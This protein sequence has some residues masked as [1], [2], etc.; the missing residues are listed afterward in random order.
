MDG[1]D[2]E[3]N[4][5]EISP[6]NGRIVPV[7]TV[8]ETNPTF[9]FG[10]AYTVEIIQKCASQVTKVLDKAFPRDLNTPFTHLRRFVKREF[11]PDAIKTRI[12]NEKS[13][14]ALPVAVPEEG[15]EILEN[16]PAQ[17][18]PPVTIFV[19]IPPP[20][21]EEE[22]LRTLLAPFVPSPLPNQQTDDSEVKPSIPIHRVTIPLQPPFNT[23]QAETW[24]KTYWPT[25]FNAASPR[26]MIAPPPKILSV[27]Q[28]SIAP[29]AGYYL[30]LAGEI[31]RE[32]RRMKRGRGIG[33]VIVD[34]AIA[35]SSN[36][37]GRPH[38][39]EEGDN[40]VVA[41]AGDARYCAPGIL[42][43][44]DLE[45][46]GYDADCEGGPEFHAIM[47]AVEMV[48]TRRRDDKVAT[49][50]ESSATIRNTSLTPL[51][52]HYLCRPASS[53]QY[54]STTETDRNTNKNPGR[55]LS[56]A[57]GGYLC[58]DL[59]IYITHEPCLACSMGMLLS[60][61]RA[62]TFPR[63]GRLV[64]GGL[65]SMEVPQTSGTG[66]LETSEIANNNEN[67]DED[68][69]DRNG[70]LRKRSTYYG[71]HW[72]KELNWRAMCFEFVDDENNDLYD[73]QYGIE[74]IGDYHA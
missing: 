53:S 32:A 27:T 62:I 9:E 70:S 67:T 5:P 17:I 35:A 42:D 23:H 1:S 7:P 38:G 10:D 40:G 18:P 49:T 52:S 63:R 39:P 66:E 43:R 21:P 8:Q 47:R 54:T 6:L 45:G 31:A 34:P 65:A 48:A 37:R 68:R 14:I 24:S 28:T 74:G 33:V 59:D 73:G 55:I 50:T 29:K 26:G 11:L 61:F 58:T 36:D 16:T 69:D 25:S 4:G 72:R 51:E 60:R 71:L 13:D 2:Q 41:V 20:L 57:A 12:E 30:S 64:T 46:S 19:L 44:G 3:C 15:A 56:R 22:Q